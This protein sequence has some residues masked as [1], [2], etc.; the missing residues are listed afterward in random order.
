MLSLVDTYQGINF[1]ILGMKGGEGIWA[2]YEQWKK[3]AFKVRKGELGT[4]ILAQ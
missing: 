3:L 4:R 2:G 1:M